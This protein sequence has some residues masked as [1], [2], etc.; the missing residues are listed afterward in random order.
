MVQEKI[1]HL[2]QREDFRL[3]I[4]DRQHDNPESRLHLCRLEEIIENDF[5]HRIPLELHHNTN[6]FA[7][8]FISDLRYAFYML[9]AYQLCN[10]FDQSR[11]VDHIGKLIDDDDFLVRFLLDMGLCPY[12]DAP[13]SCR[14]GI[15][16]PLATEDDTGGRKV[17]SL[18]CTHQIFDGRVR[19]VD[20]DQQ[21]FYQLIE[22]VR[23]DI[24]RHTDSNSRTTIKQEVGYTT[25]QYIRLTHAVIIVGY[26]VNGIFVEI[27][28]K[29]FRD[30]R[31]S[32]FGITHRCGIIS[33][34]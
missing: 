16:N 22:S 3:L 19:I 28:Q 20:T 7:V 29:F 31:H 10:I 27:T 23:R 33:I 1:Q 11:L 30:L 5:A 2:H 21:S 14:V 12:L 18:D 24:G 13:S 9:F 6:S 17:R 8:R 34:N 32:R 15:R 4:D 26:K 25:R